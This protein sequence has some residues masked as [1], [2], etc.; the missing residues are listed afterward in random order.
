MR[1]VVERQVPVVVERHGKPHVVLMSIDQYDRLV[2]GEDE[3]RDWRE[4]VSRARA[5][6]R[7]DL[8]Q[9]TLV[10]P[11]EMLRAMREERDEG[12]APAC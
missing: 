12:L 11:E 3:Q 2:D 7:S 10:P 6:V 9:R 8:A 1:Y 4:L 5:H